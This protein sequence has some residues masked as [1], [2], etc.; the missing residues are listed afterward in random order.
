MHAPRA[1]EGEVEGREHSESAREAMRIPFAAAG[2]VA[3]RST[4][5]ASPT[6]EQ[7]LLLLCSLASPLSLHKKRRTL[8]ARN[9]ILSLLCR[10]REGREREG[11]K[12]K[13]RGK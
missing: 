10:K 4:F 8:A 2:A 7:E 5:F 1:T 13:K 11:G 6:I 3:C 12:K 9:T